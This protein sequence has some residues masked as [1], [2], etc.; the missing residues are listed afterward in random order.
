VSAFVI[1]VLFLMFRPKGILA[2]VVAQREVV[3]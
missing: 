3:A 1:L 2:D